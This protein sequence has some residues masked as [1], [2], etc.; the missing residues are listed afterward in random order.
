M[1]KNLAVFAAT[2]YI[3]ANLSVPLPRPGQTVWDLVP[4]K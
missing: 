2:T 4:N 3:L 1:D